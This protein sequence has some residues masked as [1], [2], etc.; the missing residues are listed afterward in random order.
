MS[1][2]FVMLTAVKR[3][4]QQDTVF[5]DDELRMQMALTVY[6]RLMNLARYLCGQVSEKLEQVNFGLHLL[7]STLKLGRRQWIIDV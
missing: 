4:A 1:Y 2:L 3:T 5:V 7:S 6:L